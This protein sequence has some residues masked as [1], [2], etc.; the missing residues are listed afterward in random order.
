MKGFKLKY[1]LIPVILFFGLTMILK[2]GAVSGGKAKL[3]VSDSAVSVKMV[4]AEY[5]NYV[6]MLLL[7]GSIEGKTTAAISAKIAGRIEAVL[8]EEGQKVRVG[9]PL[10]KLESA[11]LANSLRAAKEAAAKAQINYDLARNDFNRYQT[12]NNQGAIS[13]QQLDNATAKLKS[14]EADLASTTANLDSADKQYGNGTILAPVDGVVANKTATVGQVISPGAAL[15]V[16]EDINQVFAVVN[17]EQKDLGRIKLGQQAS[18]TVDAYEGKVFTG[19]IET[20]NP[21]AG[22]SSRMFRARVKLDNLDGALRAGMFAKVQL[23][24]GD[25]MQVL[26]VPQS[27]VIQ[28]QGLYY[29]FTGEN[30][31]A[32]RHQVEIGEVT[33]ETIQIKSGL[34]PGEQVIISS[35]NQLKDGQTV[36][37]AD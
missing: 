6:P 4:Q 5:T 22:A 21:E 33:G 27:A 11:E 16:V 2:S 31:K 15:M 17:I 1:W 30:S 32:V 29:I 35:V 14:A 36:K 34:Q 23:A 8:V 37:V 25:S 10:V 3:P 26:A 12:L 13:Q 28:K 7:N 20:I 18:V 24:T 19:T 9:D